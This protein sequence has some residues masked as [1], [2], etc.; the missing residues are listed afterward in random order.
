MGKSRDGR[1]EYI[2]YS[3]I[4]RLVNKHQWTLSTPAGQINE[5]ASH[6]C[7]R[8]RNPCHRVPPKGP[9]DDEGYVIQWIFLTPR[10]KHAR[11]SP[12]AGPRDRAHYLS[13]LTP[14]PHDI[15]PP[16]PPSH[17]FSPFVLDF[18]HDYLIG[19]GT[20]KGARVLDMPCAAEEMQRRKPL[21]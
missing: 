3:I 5:F 9:R 14:W 17:L 21:P 4:P 11:D 19:H 6:E 7:W 20:E 16:H 8:L 15:G 2:P 10:A 18:S 1:T 12:R 13:G